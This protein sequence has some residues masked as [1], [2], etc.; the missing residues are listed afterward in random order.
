MEQLIKEYGTLKDDT[1]EIKLP[2][3]KG[4]RL[5]ELFDLEEIPVHRRGFNTS[6]CLTID[7][8]H[9]VKRFVGLFE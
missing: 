3:M 8:P 2:I 5:A 7:D 9:Y 4:W 6:M 1:I